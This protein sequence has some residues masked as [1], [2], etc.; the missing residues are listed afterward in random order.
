MSCPLSKLDIGSSQS[1]EMIGLRAFQRESPTW[2]A[3]LSSGS[4]DTDTGSSSRSFAPRKP[5][6]LL[7]DRS[8]VLRTVNPPAP[9]LP[10]LIAEKKKQEMEN[11]SNSG[12]DSSEET[13]PLIGTMLKNLQ[14]QVN[15]IWSRRTYS[16][17]IIGHLNVLQPIMT[18]LSAWKSLSPYIMVE[19]DPAN[20]TERSRKLGLIPMLKIR[21]PNSGVATAVS[22]TLS[23]MNFVVQSISPT[24]SDGSINIQLEW[25]LREVPAL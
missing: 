1:P 19:L 13:R 22:H 15:S 7:R 6:Q 18:I 20:P 9:L 5:S 12:S 24:C 16:F 8:D 17:A 3:N 10:K 2:S 11:R 4:Q 23:S 25:S 21:A 14:R